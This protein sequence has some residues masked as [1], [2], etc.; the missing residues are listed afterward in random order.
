MFCLDEESLKEY[1]LTG[2][3]GDEVFSSLSVSI[4]KCYDRD[5]CVSEQE[6]NQIVD[7]TVFNFGFFFQ[8]YLPN[9]YEEPIYWNQ[10][11]ENE[12]IDL[13]KQSHS[14]FKMLKNEL[15]LEDNPFGIG[16]WEE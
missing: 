10:I 9:E 12:A 11:F 5:D 2:D 16:I 1:K 3:A 4:Q 13:N 14:H 7:N 6:M 8:D 15:H